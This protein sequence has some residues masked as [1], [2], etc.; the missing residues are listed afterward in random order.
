MRSK[1]NEYPPCC[2]MHLCARATA[3][4]RYYRNRPFDQCGSCL[5][6]MSVL[7]GCSPRQG[8]CIW[9]AGTTNADQ[10]PNR[11]N[12]ERSCGESDLASCSISAGS[13][14]ADDVFSAFQA[15]ACALLRL[16]IPTKQLIK[17]LELVALGDIGHYIPPLPACA[18][19]SPARSETGE[20]TVQTRAPRPT[21]VAKEARTSPPRLAPLRFCPPTSGISQRPAGKRSRPQPVAPRVVD[22]WKR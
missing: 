2:D 8:G 11:R 17:S 14:T 18:P 3:S 4:V 20:A 5:R 7:K 21:A 15:G 1:A 6:W 9:L 10:L 12:K 22:L 16:D 19:Q 13:H